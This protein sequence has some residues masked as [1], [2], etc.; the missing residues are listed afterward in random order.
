MVDSFNRALKA[1]LDTSVQVVQADVYALTHDQLFNPAFYN[2]SNTTAPACGPNA[3]DGSALF[4]NVYNTWPGVDAS[5]FMYADW[6]YPTPYA[7]WLIA[8]WVGLYM[9]GRGWL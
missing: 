8:R 6:L 9:A 3:M 5:H 4:C 2:L 7:H 1:G